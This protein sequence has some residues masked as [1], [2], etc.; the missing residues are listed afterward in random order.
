MPEHEHACSAHPL[1]DFR[2]WESHYHPRNISLLLIRTFI[3]PP[4]QHNMLSLSNKSGHVK[5]APNCCWTGKTMH[6]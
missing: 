2:V 3:Q 5:I 4:S 6:H 1:N